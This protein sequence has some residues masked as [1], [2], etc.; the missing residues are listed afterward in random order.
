MRT[1]PT[2]AALGL[3]ATAATAQVDNLRITEVMPTTDQVEITN[4]GPAFSVASDVRFCHRFNYASSVPAGT[5]FGAGE[6]LVF[7]VSALDDADSDLW[8]YRSPT[9]ADPNEIIH[10]VKYGPAPSVGRTQIASTVG[11]WPDATAFAPAPGAGQS[12]AF[13]GFGNDPQDWYVDATPSLGQADPSAVGTTPAGLGVPTGTADFEQVA[14]GDSVEA[15]INWPLIDGG[16]VDGDFDV[17]VVGDVEGASGP[18]PTPGSTRWLRVRDQDGAAANRFYSGT[19][20]SGGPFSYELRFFAYLIEVPP[21]AAPSKPR[22]TVQHVVNGGGFT[23]TWGIEFD[24]AGASLVVLASGGSPTI[25]PI[26]G[27]GPGA[28]S[29]IVL[30]VDFASSTVSASTVSGASVTAQIAPAGNVDPA[31]LRFCYRGEGA[32][33]VA[34]LLFDDIGFA[35]EFC[36]HDLGFQGPGTAVASLCG[37][38]LDAGQRS[39]YAVAGA[40]SSALGTLLVSFD[41]G[42]NTSIL[43]GTLVSIGTFAFSVPLTADASGALSLDV[44]GSSVVNDFVLQSVFL[45]PSTVGGVAFT[46]AI[47]ARAGQ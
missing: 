47:L 45:D 44:G 7:T 16:S 40:P 46:N 33:N 1:I 29:E 24:E 10:G 9:F 39:T 41:G 12:L 30:A 22:V 21:V 11:L 4:T 17:R 25:L 27:T 42:A 2:L 5:V 32:G 36:Q 6:A 15:L 38:G 28:W 20:N 18:A 31:G 34:T 43:G 26:G 37:F 3:V 8:I 13:D 19:L 35:F 23:N 14:L